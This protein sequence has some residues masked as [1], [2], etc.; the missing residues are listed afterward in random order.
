MS[1]TEYR[2]SKHHL[3]LFYSRS[4]L[5]ASFYTCGHIGN[6]KQKLV[7]QSLSNFLNPTR[8]AHE[9]L[10]FKKKYF[11]CLLAYVFPNRILPCSLGW[12]GTYYM[13]KLV[14]IL[15]FCCA[16]VLIAV[17][18]HEHLC[19]WLVYWFRDSQ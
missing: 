2:I 13:H 12:S 5:L 4:L 7:C 14:S 11:V 15:R 6:Y 8:K 3:C 19:I 9:V 18:A 17:S 1:Q 16:S 10:F